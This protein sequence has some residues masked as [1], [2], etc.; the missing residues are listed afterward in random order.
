MSKI[1]AVRLVNINYNN[2]TIRVSDETL[3][4]NT[5]STLV[6]LRNGGGKSVLVQMLTAPFVHKRYRDTQDRPFESYF[7]T[8]KPSFI[9]TEWKL[10]DGAGYLLTA[11]MVRKNQNTEENSNENLE[12]INFVSE[13]RSSCIC[14][15]NNIPVTIKKEKEIVLKNYGVC[16]EMFES[17]KKDKSLKFYYYDMSNSSQQRQY[18]DKISE[19]KINYKEWEDIIKKINMKES[20][21]SELFSDC[22]DEKGLIEKW[23]IDTIE[24]KLDND[25]SKIKEFQQ[26]MLKYVINY[27][28]NESKIKSRDTINAFGIEAQKIREGAEIYSNTEEKKRQQENLIA[29]FYQKLNEL[30]GETD[31]K[32]K[33]VLES[34]KEID[35]RKNYIEYEE[36]SLEL[37]RL[38]KGLDNAISNKVMIE[39]ERDSI[40]EELKKAERELNIL[41]CARQYE[42]VISCREELDEK[43]QKAEIICKKEEELE[44]ER[45]A[46]GYMLNRHYAAELEKILLEQ[47]KNKDE[48]K[49]TKAKIE[50]EKK[51]DIELQ[52]KLVEAEK[53]KSVLEEK[54]KMYDRVENKF[55]NEYSGDLSRNILGDYESGIIEV[56]RDDY[57]KAVEKETRENLERK[58]QSEKIKEQIKAAVRN[59]GDTKEK[60]TNKN[61]EKK[62]FENICMQYEEELKQRSTVLEYLDLKKEDIFETEKIFSSVRKKLAQIDEF[63]RQL[64][65]EEAA[66]N[67]E[68]SRL[69]GGKIVELPKKFESELELLGINIVYGMEWLKKN[70]YTKE[71]NEHL[72]RTHKFL[73]YALILSENDIIKLSKSEKR[74]Y[75]S[76]PVPIIKREE[77]EKGGIKE[78]GNIISFEGISFYVFFNENLLDEEKLKKM[79]EEIQRKLEKV[80]EDINIRK[81]EYE[82]YLSYEEVIKLQKVTKK[83]YEDTKAAVRKCEEES[84]MLNKEL[85]EL[86][87]E[88]NRLEKESVQLEESIRYSERMLEFYKNRLKAFIELCS[89][90]E[91]YKDCVRKLELCLKEKERII[92]RQNLCKERLRGLE[93]N[94]ERLR[95]NEYVIENNLSECRKRSEDY[96]K[97]DEDYN[98]SYIEK[99]EEKY[100]TAKKE[101]S[102]LDIGKIHARYAAVSS[103]ISKERAEIEEDIKRAGE[104]YDNA[105]DELN[106]IKEKYEI[107]SGEYEQVHYSKKAE[108][109]CEIRIEDRRM[110]FKQKDSQWHEEDKRAGI[111]MRDVENCKL[112]MREAYHTEEPVPEKEILNKDFEAVKGKLA[113]EYKEKQQEEEYLKGKLQ[114]LSENIAAL[115][116]YSSL[117][118]I[119]KTEWEEDFLTFT[120]QKLREFKGKL[121]RDYNS[122]TE[123]VH[124]AKDNLAKIINSI[125]NKEI[126]SEASFRRPLE[127]ML[128]LI[129]DSKQVSS[130]L[131]T[132]LKAHELTLNKLQVD[133]QIVESERDDIAELF[134]DYIKEVHRNLEKIDANSTITVRERNIKMLKIQ[135]PEWEDENTLYR[136]RIRDF[137]DDVTVKSSEA[138][139]R[140]ENATEYIGRK[141]TTRNLYDTVIGTG[142]VQI[143]LY[144]I[145]EQREYPITWAQVAKNSGGE[146]FLSAF[147]VLASLLCYMR[148]DETDIFAEHNEGKVL[149]MDNPFAQTNAAHLLKPLMEMAK[150]TNTQLICFTGLGGESIYS[151]FDNI[152]VLN[153]INAGLRNNLSYLKSEHY[154]GEEPDIMLAS[155]IEIT[156]KQEVLF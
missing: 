89:E 33:A 21:L 121:I 80:R 67:G 3:H 10:D 101:I 34:K 146:G 38:N 134:E 58:K 99:H 59:A 133:I 125:I 142:N 68:Y 26:L 82:K 147:I 31:I 28:N 118:V 151:R 107:S 6:S 131:E 16:L 5:E 63:R 153:L 44:P 105:A 126:F 43:L 138:F 25:K 140:N 136:L 57:S 46:L 91:K 150:K 132:T 48:Q 8:N 60:I 124:D 100:N 103:N 122:I 94:K 7:T 17:Y 18:F 22:K 29:N 65:N 141:V 15:I 137:V 19:Y 47:S 84:I 12:I 30:Y 27:R 69:A 23:F 71:E 154:K 87:E 90:Y 120:Q 45:N 73:P 72:V 97:Y 116:E 112:K 42:K 76:F 32:Y 104:K 155:Q 20:G 2:N 75:T 95:N 135:L 144:K 113:C 119:S 40:E 123:E 77:L 9:M 143:R 1:N 109:N 62:H 129:N 51:T 117:D 130:Q 41:K 110:K 53:D 35:E 11:M 70:N 36:K 111:I 83:N 55:N 56:L 128:S 13:Y 54:K 148:K 106:E 85:Q 102:A 52:G 114:N 81:Q 108:S 61:Y 98:R 92:N 37:H 127:A 39:I 156:E 74:M 115:S 24:R 139:D 50:A 86:R 49:N 78:G 88:E 64:E 145:E 14:D 66:L 79:L 93:E 4:F 152:Y 149:L 96:K